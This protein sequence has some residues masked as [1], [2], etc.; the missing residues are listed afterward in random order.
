MNRLVRILLAAAIVG[1]AG[2][3]PAV[4]SVAG[5]ANQGGAKTWTDLARIF[6]S[7]VPTPL[8]R[9]V[10]GG[11][12]VSD[13]SDGRLTILLLG[14]DTHG[15]GVSRTDTIMVMSLRGNSISVVSIPRDTARIPNPDGGTFKPRINGIVR[16][17]KAGGLSTQQALA[18]FERVIEHLLL[19]EI[20]YHAV[21]SFRGFES[22][23]GEIEPVSVRINKGIA[24]PKYWDDPDQLTGVYF[25][26]ST[27]YDLY[28]YQPGAP[29]LLCN[30]QWRNQSQPIPS[31]YWCRR[32]LPFVRSRKGAS[33]SDFSRAKRQQDF[34]VAAVKRVISRGSGSQLNSLV[35]AA[36]NAQNGG[37]LTTN[38]PINGSNAID[39]FNRL[40]GAS[41]S[42]QTVFSPPTY[43][44]HISGG[45]AFELK[46]PEVR[47][48][49]KQWF[50]S[51]G[52]PPP[53]APPTPTATASGAI[54]TPGQSDIPTAPPTL[55]PGQTP[56]VA[57][58]LAP[59]ATPTTPP[60]TPPT[61]APGATPAPLPGT[62]PD[63]NVT[64]VPGTLPTPVPGT[65]LDPSATVIP[66]SVP[67]GVAVLPGQSAA[68]PGQP[69][70]PDSSPG[71]AVVPGQPAP[72]G[73]QG[74]GLETPVVLLAV[75]ALLF[76]IAIIGLLFVRRRPRPT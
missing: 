70:G 65:T 39:L 13:G 4:A 59:G 12:A 64:P 31:Q 54:P 29:S 19:V 10:E 40:N 38:I 32:A 34:V 46:L 23:V 71:G 50:G 62:T 57:P 33:N 66:G 25:P 11:Q 61:L 14:S 16:H 9:M 75:G 6:G 30:G 26:E 45:T 63:P 41:L 28:E 56:T 48:V 17:L 68:P 15:A 74:S 3:F 72:G 5:V 76:G 2:G 47:R 21:V 42:F 52:A 18:E 69:G 22:L 36:N 53:T 73:Q 8:L 7:V 67:T 24:D 60:T 51:T 1:S 55:A 58:T 49:M 43:A 27:D 44:T 35:S 20:D 37:I